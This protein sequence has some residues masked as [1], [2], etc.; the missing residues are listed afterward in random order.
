[1]NIKIEDLSREDIFNL[2]QLLNRSCSVISS[3]YADLAVKAENEGEKEAATRYY[4]EGR[5]LKKLLTRLAEKAKDEF[6][7][8]MTEDWNEVHSGNTFASEPYGY[9][10]WVV[11][12]N[13]EGK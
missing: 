2:E 8:E 11:K 13:F 12:T 4:Y 3:A 7:V 6:D 10:Q 9:D 1:M 5:C